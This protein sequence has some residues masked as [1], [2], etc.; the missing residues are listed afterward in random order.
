MRQSV[1]KLTV[2]VL[3]STGATGRH[4]VDT[5]LGRGNDVIALARHT[6]T[7]NPASGL[8]EVAWADL[9]DTVTLVQAFRGIDAVISTLGGAAKGR[10]TVC[11]D[12]IR[13]AIA[14]MGE[15]SVARLIAVSAHG[16][17]D[18]HDKS[19]YSMAVWAGVG[20]KMRDKETMEP[21]IVNSGLD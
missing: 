9:E 2:A 4:V 16:V 19:L 13:S 11:T 5:A 20:H 8:R 6:G 7:F 21:L 14:A 12:G 18:T 3:G 17:A 1:S 10:T 15:A